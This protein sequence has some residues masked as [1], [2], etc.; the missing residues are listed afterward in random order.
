LSETA[1]ADDAVERCFRLYKSRQSLTVGHDVE[2]DLRGAEMLRLSVTKWNGRLRN[3]L[4][5][6]MIPMAHSSSC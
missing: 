2:R 3:R 6:S 4:L 1:D 5:T